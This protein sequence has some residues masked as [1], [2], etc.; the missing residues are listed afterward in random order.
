M[1]RLSKQSTGTT[2]QAQAEPILKVIRR[3]CVECSAET[4]RS[5]PLP[6]YRVLPV[7]LPDGLQSIRQAAGTISPHPRRFAKKFPANC[8][9]N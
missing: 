6:G 8:G 3:K 2:Q 1:E 4:V 5:P 7:A 9:E